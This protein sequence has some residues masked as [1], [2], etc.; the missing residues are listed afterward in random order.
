M[1]AKWLV[2]VASLAFASVL[3]LTNTLAHPAWDPYDD[4]RFAPITSFGPSVGVE[5]SQT[6]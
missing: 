2:S 6:G 3:P 4:T 5:M 1:T